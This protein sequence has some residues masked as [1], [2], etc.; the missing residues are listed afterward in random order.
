E[1]NSNDKLYSD[2]DPADFYANYGGTLADWNPLAAAI[3]TGIRTVDTNTPIIMGG[4]SY[5]SIFWLNYI[6]P[7]G[8]SKTVYAVHYY[9]PFHSTTSPAPPLLTYPGHFDPD[10]FSPPGAVD[11][12]KAWLENEL[13]PLD[14]WKIAHPTLPLVIGEFGVARYAGGAE[15]YMADVT[16]IFEAK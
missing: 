9:E 6:V 5:S 2:F 14:D 10:P 1:P 16:S 11:V 3:T 13:S 7:T 15:Q 8:D 12:N 4:M